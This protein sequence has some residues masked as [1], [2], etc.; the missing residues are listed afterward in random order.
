MT[1]G[2]KINTHKVTK[3]QRLYIN[4]INLLS[5][6]YVIIFKKNQKLEKAPNAFIPALMGGESFK[7]VQ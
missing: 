2:F 5:E 6:D 3:L 7:G 4:L 1:I